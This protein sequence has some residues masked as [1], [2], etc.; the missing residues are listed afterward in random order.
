MQLACYARSG[1]GV[2]EALGT[3]RDERCADV[4]EL[5]CVGAALNA[6]HTDH[7]NCDPCGHGSD[8][9]ERNGADCGS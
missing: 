4:E 3:D 7:R 9:G 2:A 6:A 5:P 8:L 1:G